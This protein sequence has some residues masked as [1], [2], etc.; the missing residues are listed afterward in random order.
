MSTRAN[1]AKIGIF[2]LTGTAIVIVAVIVLGAGALFQKTVPM[3]TYIDESVQGLDVGSPVK[4]LGVQ[5][6]NV[7]AI[8]FV[9]RRYDTEKPY[10]LIDVD[11]YSDFVNA[12]SDWEIR[13]TLQEK[14]EQGLR[15]RLA[16]QGL[17]GVAYLEVDYR[18]PERNPVLPIDWEPRHIYIPSA[19]STI[20]RV[21]ESV[22][23]VFQRLENTNIEEVINNLNEFLVTLTRTVENVEVKSMSEET[24]GALT[25]LRESTERLRDLLM[26]PDLDSVP[27][28]VSATVAGARRLSETT[29]RNWSTILEN[30]QS[31]SRRLDASAERIE[32]LLAADHLDRS[33]EDL[34]SSMDNLKSAT[35]DLPGSA[36]RLVS[37][38]ERFEGFLQRQQ[39]DLRVILDNL[40]DVSEN[41]NDLTR[42]ARDYPS[43]FIFGG[44]PPP[45]EGLN[46]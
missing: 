13:E 24:V 30:L 19:P 37:A 5:I 44:P 43:R 21:T 36:E 4:Y 23:Q 26:R 32:S 27:A 38:V 15:V 31:A 22:D 34:S 29:E 28:D 39:T 9:N 33:L 46:E 40:R 35:D 45:S 1:Y 17:T 25:A 18:D 14:V 3:E 8:S 42:D 6:G 41:L 7:A 10:V 20:T 12:K 16:S 11:L 2:V